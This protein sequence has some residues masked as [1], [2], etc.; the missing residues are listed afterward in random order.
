MIEHPERHFGNS[1]RWGV[2]R[3]GFH[4][5]ASDYRCE[6]RHVPAPSACTPR[7]ASI[8]SRWAPI[9]STLAGAVDR[10]CVLTTEPDREGEQFL[11]S[12]LPGIERLRASVGDLPL[13]ADGGSPE[14]YFPSCAPSA[15]TRW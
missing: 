8:R 1:R 11:H 5:E 4:L 6:P 7:S 9:S 14:K 13:Q 15:S 2:R 3:V 12:L 10:V